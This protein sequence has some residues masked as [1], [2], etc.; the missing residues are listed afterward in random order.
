[1]NLQRKKLDLVIVGAQKAGTTSLLRFLSQ[2]NDVVGHTTKEFSFF[3]NSSEY[4]LGF[5]IAFKKYFSEINFGKSIIAKNV[6][7]SISQEGLDKLKRHNQDIKIVFI[8]RE[9]IGRSYSAYN[10]A[11][12]DGWMRRDFLEL[13]SIIQNQEYDDI[14]YRHFIG[15]GLYIEQ[16]LN[17]TNYFPLENIRVY[18]YEDLTSKPEAICNDIFQWLGLSKHPIA[19]R[20]HNETFQPRSLK[21]SKL[22][23]SLRQEE[24]QLKKEVKRILPYKLYSGLSQKILKLNDSNVRYEKIP[25]SMVTILKP[26]FHPYNKKLYD[27]LFH[28]QTIKVRR[29]GKH[30]WLDP[31][32]N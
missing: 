31:V 12:K 20:I 24:N 15:H 26:H 21:F 8:I 17:L 23:D 14:M 2:H 27:Y 19:S 30:T 22:L 10:M 9:P 6:T 5:S 25:E 28:N 1:M 13:R 7:L 16:V 32:K 3:T 29:F 11:V 18:F 4:E